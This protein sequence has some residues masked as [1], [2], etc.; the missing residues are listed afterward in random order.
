MEK[1]NTLQ[2]DSLRL[3]DTY[4]RVL[5][6][7]IFSKKFTYLDLY[8]ICITCVVLRGA[9]A[10]W[11]SLGVGALL[12][13]G[14]AFTG[15]GMFKVDICACVMHHIFAIGITSK[16]MYHAKGFVEKC[17]SM[18]HIKRLTTAI[19]CMYLYSS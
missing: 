17:G 5:H 7:I 11:H 4:R 1:K 14:P 6:M 2:N 19:L 3:P 12:P 18:I 13:P 15:S 8:N 16:K 10:N 9:C